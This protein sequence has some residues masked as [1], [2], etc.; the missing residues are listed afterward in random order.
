MW[1]FIAYL[2]GASGMI[3]QSEMPVLFS[4]RCLLRSP[5]LETCSEEVLWELF[6]M[7]KVREL[8][9]YSCASRQQCC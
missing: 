7:A 8:V 2:F 3:W 1:N 5:F 4:F 9:F 6:A